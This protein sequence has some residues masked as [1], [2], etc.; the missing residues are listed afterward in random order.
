MM[1]ACVRVCVRA[2]TAGLSLFARVL[3]LWYTWR[4]Y[5]SFGKGLKEFGEWD[6]L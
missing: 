2:R 6:P 4:V 5:R 1:F 3:L